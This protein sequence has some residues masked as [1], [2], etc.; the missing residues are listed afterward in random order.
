MIPRHTILFDVALRTQNEIKQKELLN[1]YT[2]RNGAHIH[3][4]RNRHRRTVTV[5]GVPHFDLF[6]LA[7][8][9]ALSRSHF[10]F[11]CAL[12]HV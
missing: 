5:F 4:Q 11:L 12:F 9:V 2:L 1:K 10:F 3:T 8:T 7:H 6:H